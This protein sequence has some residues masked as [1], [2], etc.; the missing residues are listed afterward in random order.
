MWRKAHNN[1][2]AASAHLKINKGIRRE[3]S[4]KRAARIMSPWALISAPCD[5]V[6]LCCANWYMVH[7]FICRTSDG[8]AGK[9][10]SLKTIRAKKAKAWAVA[11]SWFNRFRKLLVRYEKLE[12][13]F[14]ALNHLAAAAIV[15][16]ESALGRNAM[17]LINA[18]SN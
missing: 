14:I 7:C 11:H 6:V 15:F 5:I 8:V 18:T 16:Q 10:Q 9:R 12:R 17:D 13:S 2:R 4:G 3:Q 1:N